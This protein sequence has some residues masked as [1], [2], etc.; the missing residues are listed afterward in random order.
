MIDVVA[1]KRRSG[2]LPIQRDEKKAPLPGPWSWG[3]RQSGVCGVLA[4]CAEHDV[5]VEIN[6][7]PNPGTGLAM[8]PARPRARLPPEHQPVVRWGMAIARKGGV[9][10]ERVL[11]AMDL[12]QLMQHL[13]RRR[14]CPAG[15]VAQS[16]PIQ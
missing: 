7:N 15:K 13:R 14:Q 2:T 4:A 8:A 1:S 3:G 5:A 11:N 16:I 10:K 12:A 9:P 6:S